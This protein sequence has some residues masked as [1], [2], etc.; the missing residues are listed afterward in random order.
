[1]TSGVMDSVPVLGE[2]WWC[3]HHIEEDAMRIGRTITVIEAAPLVMT[4]RVGDDVPENHLEISID[5]SDEPV[6]AP[7]REVTA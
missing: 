2:P 4:G 3:H 5:T 6:E 1:M 7:A